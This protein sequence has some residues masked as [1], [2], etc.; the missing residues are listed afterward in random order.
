MVKKRSLVGF[1]LVMLVIGSLVSPGALQSQSMYT[2]PN[3]TNAC[4]AATYKLFSPNMTAPATV[5]IAKFLTMA[6][7]CNTVTMNNAFCNPGAPALTLTLYAGAMG[8]QVTMSPSC[9]WACTGG[10]PNV[11]TDGGVDGLPVE[12]M[13]FGFEEDEPSE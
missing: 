4:L 5:V 12:L 8:T 6:R 3:T 11:T 2:I 1:V 9:Q 7:T 13:G 10:C